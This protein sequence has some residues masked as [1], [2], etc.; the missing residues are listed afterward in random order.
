MSRR[1]FASVA[2]GS[3]LSLYELSQ[4]MLSSFGTSDGTLVLGIDLPPLVLAAE[5]LGRSAAPWMCVPFAVCV[6]MSGYLSRGYV[7]SMISQ[8]QSVR[9]FAWKALL[10]SLVLS[11][12]AALI[13]HGVVLSACMALCNGVENQ[14]YLNS[15]VG[16]GIR[17]LPNRVGAAYGAA[18]IT[19][20]LRFAA[21]G[22]ASM[23]IALSVRWRYAGMLA[24]SLTWLVMSYTP[25]SGMLISVL[26]ALGTSQLVEA[27]P[28]YS[29][30]TY[31]GSLDELRSFLLLDVGRSIAVTISSFLLAIALP[32]TVC[33]GIRPFIFRG[34]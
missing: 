18:L 10:V 11:G 16:L 2:F 17:I 27:F 14:D 19:S 26:D 30:M 22:V 12:V 15:L 34:I 9:T 7:V 23:A 28:T 6:E 21:I 32:R 8:G 29:L 33:Q 5:L 3:L 4:L 20:V 13:V 25:I 1:F 24:L 31:T